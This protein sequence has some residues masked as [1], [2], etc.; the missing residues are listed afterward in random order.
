MLCTRV[1]FVV[2]NCQVCVDCSNIKDAVD[3]QVILC[4][5]RNFV[6]PQGCDDFSGPQICHLH[7]T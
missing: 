6:L 7:K 2:L 3:L 4:T 1:L 5:L